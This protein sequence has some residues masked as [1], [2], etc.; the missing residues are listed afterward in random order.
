ME[1]ANNL[2]KSQDNSGLALQRHENSRDAVLPPTTTDIGQ[3]IYVN[4][5]CAI[6]LMLFSAVIKLK[7]IFS[8]FKI[9]TYK[10]L[11]LAMFLF[12]IYT[13]YI[14]LKSL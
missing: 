4:C 13:A 12:M 14:I 8:D 11:R 2:A 3:L 5:L 9:I 7:V 10:D 1:T 6:L